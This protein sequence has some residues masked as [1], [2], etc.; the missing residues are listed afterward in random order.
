MILKKIPF[1]PWEPILLF[2]R[3]GLVIKS[4]LTNITLDEY[5][6]LDIE[7]STTHRRLINKKVLAEVVETAGE[8]DGYDQ[9]EMDDDEMALKP[10]IE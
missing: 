2:S 9:N 5:I 6:D 3:K 1:R 8:D 4:I 7:V 10:G